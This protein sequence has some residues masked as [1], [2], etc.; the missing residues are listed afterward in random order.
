[1]IFGELG[2]LV[3]RAA[4]WENQFA[5]TVEV[6]NDPANGRGVRCGTRPVHR[7]SCVHASLPMKHQLKGLLI[8]ISAN[9]DLF[10]GRTEDH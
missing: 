6:I 5:S 7:K 9:N 3:F 1:M 2:K 8:L 4:P 10:Y